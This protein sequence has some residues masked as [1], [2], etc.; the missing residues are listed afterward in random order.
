M[1][2]EEM[3]NDLAEAFVSKVWYEAKGLERTSLIGQIY[4]ELYYLEETSLVQ[5]KLAIEAISKEVTKETL[6][7]RL[8]FLGLLKVNSKIVRND[9][10]LPFLQIRYNKFLHWFTEDEFRISNCLTPDSDWRHPVTALSKDLEVV[11]RLPEIY[12]NLVALS[13]CLQVSNKYGS[14]DS[15]FSKDLDLLNEF[16]RDTATVVNIPAENFN[17]TEILR[18]VNLRKTLDGKELYKLL[19]CETP[20]P[21]DKRDSGSNYE[22]CFAAISVGENYVAF[23]Q[24]KDGYWRV[25]EFPSWCEIITKNCGDYDLPSKEDYLRVIWERLI[26]VLIGLDSIVLQTFCVYPTYKGNKISVD[27][28]TIATREVVVIKDVSDLWRFVASVQ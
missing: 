7:N 17:T 8:G 11:K 5:G 25:I 3:V 1:T 28:E 18:L 12:G 16:M 23:R 24:F 20:S 10:N 9:N 14:W 15:L 6:M 2:K 13:H 21:K 27:L 22:K 4:E 26:W 19:L